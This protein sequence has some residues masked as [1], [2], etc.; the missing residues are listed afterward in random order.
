MARDHARIVTRIWS[1]DFRELTEAEQ[2][3]YL[4]VVSDGDLNHCG[5]GPLTIKRWVGQAANST[6]RGVRKTLD[7]LAAARYLVPDWDHEEILVRTLLRND[8]VMRQP[9]VA[10]SAYS[11][12]QR[13]RS[14]LIRAH[15]LFEVH[16]I[17]EGPAS[18]YH[19]KTFTAEGVG[20]WLGEPFP[21]GLLEGFPKP[22][23]RGMANGS[24]NGLAK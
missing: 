8:R 24:A 23:P 22:W 13:I 12:W 1:G 5:V 18:E 7:S 4:M 14:P 16:R 11:S 9:N 2:R 19:A 15:V 21:K 20:A 3:L 10:I 17:H 6:E